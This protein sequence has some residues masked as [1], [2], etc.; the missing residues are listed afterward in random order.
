M[1]GFTGSAYSLKDYKPVHAAALVQEPVEDR[2]FNVAVSTDPEGKFTLGVCRPKIAAI[3][4]RENNACHF[5]RVRLSSN[6]LLDHLV[7]SLLG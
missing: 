7:T 4:H 3:I 2:Q 6:E 5:V 1:S